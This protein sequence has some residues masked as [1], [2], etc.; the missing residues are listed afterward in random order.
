MS[1]KQICTTL[2]AAG[3]PLTLAD[4]AEKSGVPSNNAS[5]VLYNLAQAN[6]VEKVGDAKPYGWRIANVDEAKKR[7]GG[8][9]KSGRKPKV[10]ATVE[11]PAKAKRR[12]AAK[13]KPAKKR[14]VRT[15]TEFPDDRYQVYI[16]QDGDLQIIDRENTDVSIQMTRSEAW[17]LANFLVGQRHLIEPKRRGA[18]R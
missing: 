10:E 2:I 8:G 15:A 4:I 18:R 13:S 12:K 7:A 9:M 16:D 11:K 3:G 6:V 17:K 1:Q 5:A 14:A